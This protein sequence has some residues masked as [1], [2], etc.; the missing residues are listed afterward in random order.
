MFFTNF[1]LSTHEV[2]IPKS[3]MEGIDFTF[4]S[5]MIFHSFYCEKNS[6]I[7]K[8]LCFTST[9][10]SCQVKIL[11]WDS[12]FLNAF[13]TPSLSC[14]ELFIMESKI[15]NSLM[16]C[17]AKTHP[18]SF[19]DCFALGFV[20]AA[21]TTGRVINLTTGLMRPHQSRS[22]NRECCVSPGLP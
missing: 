20:F 2:R 18:Y 22:V 16:R 19:W 13:D 6:V 3:L 10:S 11:Q 15:N 7:I 17:Q 1:L 8:T 21:R 9:S 4:P 12:F 5:N 14:H